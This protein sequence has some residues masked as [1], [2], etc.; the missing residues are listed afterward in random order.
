MH[1]DAITLAA[2]ADE[3]RTLLAGARIDTIIQPTEH[4]I[5]LQCYAPAAQEQG[6]RNRWLYL[7]AHPQMARVHLTA[8]KPAKMASEPPTFVMLLRK[9]L[10]GARIEQIVQ[11]RWERMLEIVAGYRSSPDSDERVRFRLIVE[12]M[13]R[14]SNIIFCNE[15]GQI[16]GCLKRVGADVNRYRVVAPGVEY[17]PPPPQQRS[18]AGRSLPRLEP[19]TVTAAQLAISAVEENAVEVPESP[20]RKSSRGEP[21]LWQLLTDHL[22]GCSPLLAREAVFRTTE[23][24]ETLRKNVD[25]SLWEELAWNIR[26]LTALYDTHAW[27]PQL[28]E[29]ATSAAAEPARPVAFAP[30]V[31]EQYAVLPE[32]QIRQSPSINV[33][34]DEYFARSEWN[35][36]MEGVR[37]PIRKILQTHL[38]RC[39]RK[40]ELLQKEMEVSEEAASYRL[41]GDLLLAY[42]H[43]VP[44]GQTSIEL[45]NFLEGD[46]STQLVSVPLDPRFDA[47]GNANR[48]FNKYHK[49]RRA[50]ELVPGQIEQNAVEMA[51]I[52]QLLADLMLA[53]TPPEVALVKAEVQTAGY[54]RGKALQDKKALKAAK[55]GKGN[56]Q[57]GK[58]VPPG[59]GVP[60][61]LRNRDGFTLLVGKNSRQNEE[62]TFRQ[63]AST[64]IWLHARGVP[65]AHVIIKAAGR[66]IPRGTIERAASVA[67][68]YSQA[69]GGKNVPVDYTLQRYVRHMKGGGPGMVTYERERT[70]YAEPES[71]VE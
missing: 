21:R 41:F 64:D 47:V 18:L 29:R 51:T 49:L 10:E 42:Q 55:K 16:L 22:L 37:A 9:Y 33:L 35:D 43:E 45:E 5:A 59:G 67:A 25:E 24:G 50:L 53:E 30:Y 27:R 62:V 60:L 71:T 19:T 40:A 28:V 4:A 11:P 15:Q 26:E 46:Q 6:G 48:F 14:H 57:K 2:V 63:A 44:R 70:V 13:G 56:K 8:L 65:G 31:L 68:Y 36:A 39:K 17:V 54:I 32:M 12:V 61:Q 66:E 69:R 58:A 7:S 23:D 3:W 34:L 1:V 20:R 38:E 52:E